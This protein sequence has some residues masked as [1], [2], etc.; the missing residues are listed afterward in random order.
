M[1]TVIRPIELS[2]IEEDEEKQYVDRGRSDPPDPE[3]VSQG[4][5]APGRLS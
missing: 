2:A 5:M 3:V 4:R 1:R